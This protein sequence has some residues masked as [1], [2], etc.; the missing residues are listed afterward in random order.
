MDGQR[1]H[2]KPHT[3]QL[4][5]LAAIGTD[6]SMRF[7]NVAPGCLRVYDLQKVKEN[8]VYDEIHRSHSL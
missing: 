3:K 2:R 8:F 4:A 1:S 6:W 7:Y 5:S